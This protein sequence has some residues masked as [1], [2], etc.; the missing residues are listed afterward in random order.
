[1]RTNPVWTNAEINFPN[2]L[3][4]RLVVDGMFNVTSSSKAAWYMLFAGIYGY[5]ITEAE[6]QEALGRVA[7]FVSTSIP[8]GMENPSGRSLAPPP[9]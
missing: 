5:V 4:K 6:P 9:S 8:E 7:W 2:L 3:A 1:M